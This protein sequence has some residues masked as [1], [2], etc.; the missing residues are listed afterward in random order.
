MPPLIVQAGS[1]S[2]RRLSPH[3]NPGLEIVYIRRG[4][5]TWRTEDLEESVTP[6]MVYFTLPGQ[7]HGSAR[8]F[9]PGHE[10]TY[11]IISASLTRNGRLAWPR[12]L[13]F[14][15]AEAR[16][17]SS[18][19]TGVKRHAFPATS[20][21]GPLLAELVRETHDPGALDCAKVRHLAAAV[22]IELVRSVAG[23]RNRTTGRARAAVEMRLLALI[24]KLKA[25]PCKK[26]TLTELAT[27]CKLGRSQFST[28]FVKLTGDTPVRFLNGLRVQQACRML[29]ETGLP[30]TRIALD[31][32]FESSQ[33][34]ARV[35]KQFT[36][37]LDARS[38]RSGAHLWA[39]DG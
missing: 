21:L 26:W 14:S 22:I 33:Y 32:G 4:H 18:R 5:L 9:E 11:A 38:Y 3:R 19:L 31:C 29:R 2:M 34:F 39:S 23:D 10:W 16:E 7:L 13:P 15:A 30:V 6:G 24:G 36:G 12:D 20:A 35:F 1:G 37:G 8:E 17:I 27:S 28:L 25:D